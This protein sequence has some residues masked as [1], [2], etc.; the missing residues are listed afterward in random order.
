MRIAGVTAHGVIAAPA[1]STV[2]GPR[3]GLAGDAGPRGLP[4]GPWPSL[5]GDLADPGEE[6]PLAVRVDPP[7]D[8]RRLVAV[9]VVVRAGVEVAPGGALGA[10]AVPVRL[11]AN[12]N[13]N[14][15]SFS[16]NF[17]TAQ[18]TTPTV[19]LGSG[20]AGASMLLNYGQTNSGRVGVALILPVVSSTRPL[21]ASL[22]LS[23]VGLR[24]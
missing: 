1:T 6:R 10:T 9:S 7:T 21:G 19:I 5:P 2:N 11:T 17:N 3:P 4:V 14:G 15:V 13:E 23:C 16:L 22:K 12:G 8:R 20:A 24:A 18:L